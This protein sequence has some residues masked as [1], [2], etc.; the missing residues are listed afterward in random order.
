MI[1]AH[2]KLSIPPK[3]WLEM[4]PEDSTLTAKCV[5][6]HSVANHKSTDHICMTT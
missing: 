2:G 1:M 6:L 5:Q 4:H 3:M